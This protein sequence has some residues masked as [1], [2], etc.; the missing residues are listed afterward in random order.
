MEGIFGR[1]NEHQVIEKLQDVFKIIVNHDVKKRLYVYK[2]IKIL[3]A[4][5][6]VM[7]TV[8][9][10]PAVV[11]IKSPACLADGNMANC[12]YLQRK[13]R[14]LRRP[15]TNPFKSSK[16]QPCTTSFKFKC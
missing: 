13:G 16:V 2:D 14:L 3:A 12:K 6:D 10:T 11:E 5:P 1:E 7:V 8:K 9:E 15:H 4:T